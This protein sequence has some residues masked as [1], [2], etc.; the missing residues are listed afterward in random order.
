MKYYYLKAFENIIKRVKTLGLTLQK[1]VK[2]VDL[3]R[4][5]ESV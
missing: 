1:H 5:I 3:I 2:K 4:Y